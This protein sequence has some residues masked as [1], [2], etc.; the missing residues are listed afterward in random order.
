MNPSLLLYCRPGFEKECAQEIAHAAS[1]AGVDGYV[2]SRPDSGWLL[3]VPHA[4]D[5]AA[6]LQRALRFDALVFPRQ[7]VHRV[8][9]ATA[10]P[11]TNRAA[12][13]AELATGIAAAIGTR[14]SCVWLETADTNA[15]KELSAFC[16]KFQP[17]L[18]KALRQRNLLDDAAAAAAHAPR[19]H[20]FFVDSAT[21]WLG[22]T[23]SDNSAAWPLGIPRLKSVVGAPSRSA[24]KLAEALQV[25]LTPTERTQRLHEGIT[26]VDLG[27]A[28]GGW[29]WVLVRHG[30]QVTAIDNGKLAPEVMASGQ[31]EHL[32]ADGFSWRP[33]RPVHWLVCDMVEKPARVAVL[34]AEWLASGDCEEAVFNL[35]L[36]MK[37]RYEEVERCRALIDEVLQ[38]ARV[39]YRLALRQLY[40]DREE[41][42]AHLRRIQKRN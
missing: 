28:P 8:V 11:T 3:Y 1:A 32:R 30:L 37:K 21:A 4:P 39:P 9:A 5:G 19:L 31:V 15:A 22:I 12:P 10:L 2:K 17:H 20:V 35:K 24:Q 27:A 13:L 34:M 36:P 6:Q 40:H 14:F 7:L 26:G 16:R 33:R 38:A 25:F 23:E 29:T 42:T 41:V 18:E